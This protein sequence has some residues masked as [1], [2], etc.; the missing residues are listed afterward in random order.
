MNRAIN[1]LLLLPLAGC[2]SFGTKP[3]KSLLTLTP[4]A[5]VAANTSRTSAS[6]PSITVTVP[7]A[8]VAITATRIPVYERGFAIAYVKDAVWVDA[9]PRL[10]QRVL[11]ETIAAKTGRIVLDPRQYTAQPGLRIHG[12]LP[13]FGIDADTMEAVV[14]YDAIVQRENG[15]E[16]KRFESRVPIATVEASV[17]ASAL[18]RAANAVAAQVA[19]WIA[20]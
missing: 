20:G 18:N 12:Q 8:P 7:S 9:P 16:T 5:T 11:S 14:I 15:L 10:F 6:G 13:M 17:A 1:A 19:A 3:P 2:V 4:A